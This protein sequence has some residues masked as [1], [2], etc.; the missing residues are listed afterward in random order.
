MVLICTNTIQ[1]QNINTK[2]NQIDVMKR[3]SERWKDIVS[4]VT[5]YPKRL[6]TSPEN[7]FKSSLSGNQKLYSTFFERWDSTSS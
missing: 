4:K 6:K 2:I 3:Y 5:F 7:Q 1:A